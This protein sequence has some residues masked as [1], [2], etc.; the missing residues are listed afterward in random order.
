MKDPFLPKD[1]KNESFWMI[2]SCRLKNVDYSGKRVTNN[3]FCSRRVEGKERLLLLRT[4]DETD[5][6][7]GHIDGF[8]VAPYLV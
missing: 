4:S 8:I 1:G 7:D 6:V 3:L 5:D 2:M